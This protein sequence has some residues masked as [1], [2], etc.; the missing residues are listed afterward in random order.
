MSQCVAPMFL[1]PCGFAHQICAARGGRHLAT[2]GKAGPALPRHMA[3]GDPNELN[4]SFL[5]QWTV[6]ID[7]NEGLL[8][9]ESRAI[10]KPNMNCLCELLM[11]ILW[12]I[13][14]NYYLSYTPLP[15]QS[16]ESWVNTLRPRQM[17]AISQMTS[18]NR[19]WMKMVEFRLKFH[20]SLFPR[21][22][23]TKFQHWF[24]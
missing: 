12:K 17:D 4:S 3:T 16:T 10:I 13:V 5:L 15:Y 18:S 23:L 21:V 2:P 11:Q 8:S 22:Q 19:F 1:S 24:R 6:I 9:V 7:H 20:W 14:W